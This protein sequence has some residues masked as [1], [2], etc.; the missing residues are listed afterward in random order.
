MNENVSELDLVNYLI[1][2]MPI[3]W[4]KIAFYAESDN[5][6]RSLFF[7]VREKETDIAVNMDTFFKRYDEYPISKRE[8]PFELIRFVRYKFKQDFV[9]M[10]ENVWREFVCT[11][12]E[13]GEYKFEYFYPNGEEYQYMTRAEFLKKYLDS[14]YICVNSK[15]PS[16]E[17]VPA[18]QNHLL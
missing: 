4:K 5:G 12:E 18:D 2:M 13:N 3:P 14:D 10:G 7:G 15:Y 8:A 17:F 11:I 9:E 16:K 6:S 1:S